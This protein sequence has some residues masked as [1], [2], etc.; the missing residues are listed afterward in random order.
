MERRTGYQFFALCTVTHD[1]DIV[2]HLR[3]FVK[4]DGHRLACYGLYG[5]RLV[6]DVRDLQLSASSNRE[7]ERPVGPCDGAVVLGSHF[8][9]SCPE[10]RLIA[11]IKD[12]T[13]HLYGCLLLKDRLAGH[14]GCY[15]CC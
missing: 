14:S 12:N 3:V 8:N 13:F 10:Y 5:C 6:A 7:C 11:G 9:D 1:H 15:G 4:D 2:Q